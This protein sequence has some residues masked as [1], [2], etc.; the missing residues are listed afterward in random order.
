[1]FYTCPCDMNSAEE[2]FVDL[3]N[4]SITPYF[5]HAIKCGIKLFGQRTAWK[6]PLEWIL[7]TY[8]WSPTTTATTTV[9]TRK[10]S[11]GKS[12][13]PRK[14]KLRRIRPEDVGYQQDEAVVTSPQTKPLVDCKIPFTFTFV[15]SVRFSVRSPITICLEPTF[16]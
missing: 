1:M 3:W 10:S 2:W 16:V 14:N 11:T 4:Y 15:F 7:K 8:P 9:T 12:G 13:E 6:D 5:L